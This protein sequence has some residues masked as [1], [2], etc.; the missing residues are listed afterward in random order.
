MGFLCIV[1]FFLF[2]LV[3]LDFSFSLPK[4]CHAGPFASLDEIIVLGN[5][6]KSGDNKE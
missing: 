3:F 6:F 5:D 4:K 2:F 1:R